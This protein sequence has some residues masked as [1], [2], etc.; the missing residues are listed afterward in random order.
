MARA[1]GVAAQAPVGGK[2]D[3]PRSRVVPARLE[4]LK[5]ARSVRKVSYSLLVDELL[6]RAIYDQDGNLVGL[7]PA[8]EQQELPLKTA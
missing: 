1:R 6:A 5:R 2:I 4:D 7:R 3:F 8:A